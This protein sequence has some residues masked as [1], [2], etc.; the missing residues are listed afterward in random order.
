[1]TW[2][3]Y[4]SADEHELFHMG[5]GVRYSN[6]QSDLHF[7]SKPEFN[8]SPNFIDS[9]VF[10]AK[11]NTTYNLEASWRKG[12]LWLSSEYTESNITAPEQASLT[13]SGYYLSAALSLTGEMRDY[14]KRNGTFA[15]LSVSRTVAQG[16]IGAWEV[17]T[18]WSVFDGNSGEITA[19]NSEIFSLGLFWWLNPKFNVS[20]NYR[21]INLERCSEF[22]VNCGLKGNSL[23]GESNGL[24]FRLMLM[25]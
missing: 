15:L 7:S 25:L 12:P 21:W 14:N 19:G 8:N 9:G 16:G 22:Q 11:D 1:M 2:L 13:L 5:F 10:S 4:L 6:S 18:R 3:P 17:T 20:A 23:H 24:N